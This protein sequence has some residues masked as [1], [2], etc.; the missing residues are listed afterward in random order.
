M[1]WFAVFDRLHLLAALLPAGFVSCFRPLSDASLLLAL[2]AGAD[3]RT[4]RVA[5][6]TAVTSL[7]RDVLLAA[8]GKRRLARP[9]LEDTELLVSSRAR[10]VLC[11][12]L[13]LMVLFLV[14]L[15]DA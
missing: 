12:G 6:R 3:F 5:D 14:V 4:L 8:G 13:G 11:Y 7:F 2:S 9:V 15:L 1:A 10:E